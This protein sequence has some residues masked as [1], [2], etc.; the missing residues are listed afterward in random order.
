MQWNVLKSRATVHHWEQSQL[1]W[2]QI[3]GISLLLHGITGYGLLVRLSSYSCGC[4]E[5][6]SSI[7]NGLAIKPTTWAGL[8]RGYDLKVHLE[9]LPSLAIAEGRHHKQESEFSWEAVPP[10]S[11]SSHCDPLGN[12]TQR[13]KKVFLLKSIYL[14]VYFWL[15]WVFVD[16]WAFLVAVSWGYSLLRGVSFSL[17]WLL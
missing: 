2:R 9:K 11:A 10:A 7:N 8:K 17:R 5:D 16:M 3:A 1:L 13:S 4:Q 12:G 6:S 14:C 15:C